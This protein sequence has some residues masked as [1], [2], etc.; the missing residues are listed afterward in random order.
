MPVFSNKLDVIKEFDKEF[1]YLIMILKFNYMRLIMI[2]GNQNQM[3]KALFALILHTLQG[4]DS[5]EIAG[6]EEKKSESENSHLEKSDNYSF[7]EI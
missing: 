4:A 1:I 5:E 3:D 7:A 6:K 2:Q